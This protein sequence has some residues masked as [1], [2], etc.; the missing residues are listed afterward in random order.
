MLLHLSTVVGKCWK[1]WLALSR[2]NVLGN[3]LFILNWFSLTMLINTRKK[4]KK[5]TK[6]PFFQQVQD[7]LVKQ[8]DVARLFD[9]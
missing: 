1:L 6:N 9:F 8:Q 4:L 2:S 5:R 3:Q 7:S